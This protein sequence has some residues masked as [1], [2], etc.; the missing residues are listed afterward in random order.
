MV[1]VN[2]SW[3]DVEVVGHPVSRTQLSG[4]LDFILNQDS[5]AEIGGFDL[6][7]RGITLG[8]GTRIIDRFFLG[9]D[10]FRGFAAGG[11]G[12][13]DV[14][15]SG[16]A[17]GNCDGNNVND[18]L[19]GNLYAVA[20]LQAS[21]PIGLP[22]EWGIYGGVFFDAGSLWSLD[23]TEITTGDT[24]RTIDDGM[25][26]RA[27]AGVSLFWDSAFGPLR[28]N[29]AHPIREEENDETESFRFTIG[30]RF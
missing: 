11:L 17:L 15:T 21:F 20:R 10:R 1:D 6:W 22:E 9:G 16:G 4:A 27:A 12:P 7:G 29:F 25:N 8:D 19:G 23:E 5:D 13:R 30:T 3:A 26:L 28:L 2:R 24:P 18:A 14:C